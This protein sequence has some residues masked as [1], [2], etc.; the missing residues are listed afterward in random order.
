MVLP[1]SKSKFCEVVHLGSPVSAFD[2]R[3]AVPMAAPKAPM[4]AHKNRHSI[5]ITSPKIPGTATAVAEK[6]IKNASAIRGPSGRVTR[7]LSSTSVYMS[8]MSDGS[9]GELTN[10]NNVLFAWS[11]IFGVN[12]KSTRSYLD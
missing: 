5:G 6:P 9:L 7:H 10:L 12:Q 3:K 1:R 4:H 8:A 2:Y 11:D